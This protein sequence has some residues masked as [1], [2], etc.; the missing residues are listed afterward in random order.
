M[1]DNKYPDDDPELLKR[2]IR[3]LADQ[4][5]EAVSDLNR[6]DKTTYDG[7]LARKETMEMLVAQGAPA[8]A[9]P[10]P[11]P[12]PPPSTPAKFHVDY[13][14]QV[15]KVAW[16]VNNQGRI[17]DAKLLQ[18]I[19]DGP[20]ALWF[21][22]GSTDYIKRHARQARANNEE[23]LVVLYNV[24]GRDEGNHS[25]GGAE[26]VEVYKKTV[27]A[28]WVAIG[29]TFATVVIEPDAVILPDYLDEIRIQ[30]LNYAM[31]K[32]SRLPNAKSYI[33][34]G[35]SNWRS[36]KD[37]AVRLKQLTIP[38]N[39]GLA[40]NVSNSNPTANEATYAGLLLATVGWND[41]HFIIDTSRNGANAVN[42]EWCNPPNLKAGTVATHDT[43]IS[44]CDLLAWIKRPGESDGICRG[45]PDAGQFFESWALDFAKRTWG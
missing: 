17:P 25:K 10:K 34:A 22:G 12:T 30:C 14:S 33:D 15:Q 4:L 19:A 8:P 35:H 3:Y 37:M 2:R 21:N 13:E 38:A 26:S 18:K 1:T 43:K 44:G 9:E 7:R 28:L 24:P 16:A 32:L 29:D 45:G 5:A 6:V 42:S 20:Q 36:P 23:L 40:F 39:I 27:D 31:D 41:K 11:T